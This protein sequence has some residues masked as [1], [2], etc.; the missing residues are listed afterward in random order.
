VGDADEA[1]EK[2]VRELVTVMAA[3]EAG[4]LSWFRSLERYKR[5]PTVAAGVLR[6]P[7]AR[8][9]R[10]EDRRED[11][12]GLASGNLSLREYK[13]SL[14]ETRSGSRK[15]WV[16]A[17]RPMMTAAVTVPMLGCSTSWGA[18]AWMRVVSSASRSCCS[19][20]IS[21]IR[22]SSA[23]ATRCS[24]VCGSLASWRASRADP[25]AFQR[26][27]SELRLKLGS[28]PDQVPAQPVD[29]PGAFAHQLISVVAQH[30]AR[31]GEG[32][33]GVPAG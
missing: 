20:E 1:I 22:L 29:L 23:F 28:D 6:P 7:K 15:R 9:P 13:P 21:L 14:R 26:R 10:A 17:V 16:P 12:A 30:L 3:P 18:W 2:V 31:M 27:R 11:L 24:G 4:R 19:R 32:G 33:L 5:Q 8:G 25:G